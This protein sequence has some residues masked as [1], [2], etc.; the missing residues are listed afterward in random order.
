MNSFTTA[1]RG[2]ES[3][4]A[5]EGL[6]VLR[7]AWWIDR[8]QRFDDAAQGFGLDRRNDDVRTAAR[9]ACNQGKTAQSSSGCPNAK[10]RLGSHRGA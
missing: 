9:L 5:L 7:V 2:D 8:R 10:P 1:F 4:C 6:R 3:R